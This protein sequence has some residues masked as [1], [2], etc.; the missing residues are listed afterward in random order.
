MRALCASALLLGFLAP[1]ALANPPKLSGTARLDVSAQPAVGALTAGAATTGG[2][3]VDRMTWLSPDEQ[4]RTCVG[5]WPIRHFNWTEVGLV[6]VPQSNGLVTIDLLGP[7][8]MSPTGTIYLQ[9]VLWDA[10]TAT[11]AMLTNGSFETLASGRPVGWI[12]PW[13]GPVVVGG[14][15]AAVDGTNHVAAWHDR[16]LQTTLSVTGGVPVEIRAWARAK[17]PAG[18]VDNPRIADPDSAGHRAARRFMRGVNFSNFFEAP[19]GQDWGGG[20]LGPA[21]FDAVRA[22][23]FDHVRL[24]VSWNY[25]TGPGPAHTI[26]NA[27]FVRVD[28]VVTGLLARGVN[29]LLN[30]HHFNEFYSDPAAS[31]NKLYAIWDQ[32]AAHYSGFPDALAFEILNEPHNNATT[33]FMNGVYAHLLPRLRQMHPERPMFVGP[34]QWNGIGE[35]ANLRLPADDSNLV[36]TVH[37]YAPFFYTHQGATWAGTQPYTTNVVYPGPPPA[38]VTPHPV[39][40]QDPSVVAWFDQYNTLP[41]AQNPCSSNAFAGALDLAREWSAYYG[42]PVHVGEFGAYGTSD[43]ASRVRFYRE[44]REAMDRR[45]LGWASWDWKAGFHFWDRSTNGPAPGMREAFFPTPQISWLDGVLHIGGE[46]AVGKRMVL[47]RAPDPTAQWSVVTSQAQRE[48]NFAF[49]SGDPATSA[50]FRVV[51]EYP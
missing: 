10:V 5:Y 50:I 40:A 35:L 23:G 30:L 42:R 20:P 37:S 9:E 38:P 41:T 12:N 45:G 11:G 19:A 7:W 6:F 16:R 26:S 32:L 27:F 28:A 49:A 31:T 13:G 29:V 24:P 33:E 8:E 34:G 21:D 2:G 43:P 25:H 46:A 44:M 1:P 17:L 48:I 4:A 51:W 47:Q 18:F 39:S 14:E 22:L 36:V 15:P 3:S